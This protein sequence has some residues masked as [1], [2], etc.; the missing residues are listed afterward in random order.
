MQ[1]KFST[2]VI[3]SVSFFAAATAHPKNAEP[4]GHEFRAPGPGDV[5]GPCPGLNTLANHG[6]L[7]R[8]GK[9]FTVKTLLDAGLAGF[10]VDPPPITVAAKFGIM[11]TDSPTW[12]RIDLDALSAHN[13]IE[14]DASISRND[15]GDGTGDN[16]HFNETTFAT[17][18]NSNPGKDYYDPV[19]AGEVQRARLAHSLAT[20]PF[21]VNTQKEFLLRSRESALY[22]SIFGDPATG[23]ASKEF[24]NIFFREERLPYAEG[25]Q[26][27]KMLITDDSLSALEATIHNVSQWTQTQRCGPLIL[28]DG[29][30]FNTDTFA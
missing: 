23:I 25:F 11:T 22:L 3:A 27:P 6:Y 14:H 9:Q 1:L 24:V 15:F 10:N 21:T 12:D 28:G 29:I 20:N 30:A 17:L 13:I 26:L 16:T 7:P 5:R 4:K 19:S 8:N 18:A 2:F